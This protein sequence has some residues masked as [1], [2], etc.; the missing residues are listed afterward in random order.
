MSSLLRSLA[1]CIFLAL[2]ISAAEVRPVPPPGVAIPDADR[3]ALTEGVAALGKEIDT[4]RAELKGKP[5]MLALLPDVMIFHKAVDWALRYNEFFDVKLVETAKKQ[6]ALGMERAK[7]LRDGKASWNTATGLVVRGYISKIDG[8]VQPYGMVVPDDW[9]PNEQAPRRLDFWF[10]GR[11]ET[12]TELGFIADRLKNKG[13][14][15]PPGTLVLH[16]F[17][18]YCC[19]NKFAGEVD[20]FEAAKNANTHYGIDWNRVSVRGFSMGG[21]AAWHFGTHY[22]WRWAAVAPGAGFAETAEYGRVYAPGKTPPP[23]WQQVL[24][25]WYD[26]TGYAGNLVNTTTVAYSGELDAQKQ[27]ADIMLRYAEKEGLTIPHIIGPG[28]KHAY[29]PESKPKVE[30]IVTGAMVKGQQDVPKKLHFTTYSLVY[31]QMGWVTIQGMEKQWERA[32]VDAELGPDGKVKMRT[33]NVSQLSIPGGG[34]NSNIFSPLLEIDDQ[35]LSVPAANDYYF[36]KVNGRW[37]VLGKW[38]SLKDFGLRKQPGICGP[39]DHAFMSKFIFVRPTGKPLNEKVGAW[40]VGEME[41][42][43]GF[44]RKVFRG[45]VQVKDDTAITAEDAASAHLILWGDPGSNAYLAKVVGGLPVQWTREKLVFAGQ[46]Y[47]AAQH[48]P[49][50][51]YPNPA[52]PGNYVVLN[53]S[54][55]FREEDL[56]TNSQQ[57]PKLPDWAIVNLNTPPDAKNPGEIVNAGFFDESWKVNK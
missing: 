38:G 39:I 55:T 37:W 50:L 48:A 10:R 32:D 46:T 51:I 31:P 4:L 18:R 36:L 1:L 21:A 9:K 49:V 33:H 20:L 24:Y 16:P 53:S 54:I 44:W 28:T 8:S 3:T 26:S 11:A 40:S 29:H 13:D 14:F 35:S 6:L 42:A 41:H 30:E 43:I 56:L 15:V 12:S 23:W 27:A 57:I 45:D 47:D 2:P 17:G 19:A 5:E 7:E 34:V 22:A 52:S 25:R